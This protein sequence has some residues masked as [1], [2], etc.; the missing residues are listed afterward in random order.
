MYV[1]SSGVLLCKVQ[2][3][4]SLAGFVVPDPV[5][6]FG[7]SWSILSHLPFLVEGALVT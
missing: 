7:L 3:V 6:C 4:S 2:G 5:F 1:S